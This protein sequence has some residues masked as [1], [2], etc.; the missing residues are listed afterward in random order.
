MTA[1]AGRPPGS[2]SRHRTRPVACRPMCGIVAVVGRPGDRPLRPRPSCS[3]ASIGPRPRRSPATGPPPSACSAPPPSSASVDALLAGRRRR[4]R[5]G[6]PRR[7]WRRPSRPASTASTQRRRSGSSRPRG[8]SADGDAPDGDGGA[9]RRAGPGQGRPVGR[10]PRPAPH[11]PGGGRPGR[12]R[13]RAGRPSPAFTVRPDGAVG[14][15]TASRCAAATR[16]ACTCSCWDHGLDLDSDAVR[17]L[18][19]GRGRRPPLR[20]RRRSGSPT[21]TSPSSTRRP[22]RSASWAT[23]RPALRAAI[24]ADGLLHLALGR[25]DGPGHRA[26]PHPLG[27]RRHHLRGQRPPAQPGG[28]GRSA[29]PVRGRRAQ[30]RRR[31]PRRPEGRARPAH[32]GRRSPPTPRSSPRSSRARLGARAT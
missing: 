12:P 17:R 11:R 2:G 19:A 5:P 7:T 15:S 16:P 27:Q 25:A 14:A 1:C 13:R 20:L 32:P 22:P 24:R 29:G 10:P 3:A 6:R 31:Q 28:G 4:A 21:A 18:L 9:Q 23:T 26:R 30:R 8:A